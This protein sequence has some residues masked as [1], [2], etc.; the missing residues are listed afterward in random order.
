MTWFYFKFSVLSYI[1]FLSNIRRIYDDARM[2]HRPWVYVPSLSRVAKEKSSTSLLPPRF[3]TA[4]GIKCVWRKSWR[5]Q[6]RNFPPA[7]H[8]LKLI[9]DTERLTVRELTI[10]K[11]ITRNLSTS[12]Q[13][14]VT[15]LSLTLR[16][17]LSRDTVETQ[18]DDAREDWH[19]L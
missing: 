6:N 10:R 14:W 7:I 4:S 3:Y 2:T 17:G 13:I 16:S 11:G 18:R 8:R 19:D 12:S 5:K 15:S 1:H 9:S